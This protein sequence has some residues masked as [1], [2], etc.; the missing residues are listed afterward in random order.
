MASSFPGTIRRIR[1]YNSDPSR[2]GFDRQEHRAINTRPR[3]DISS[4]I[5]GQLVLHVIIVLFVS[6]GFESLFIHHGL[7]AMDEGW[8]LHAAMEMLDG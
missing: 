1:R 7:S 4:G 3:T 5:D 2:D 6:I 8:P